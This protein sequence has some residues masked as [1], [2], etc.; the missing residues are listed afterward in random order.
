MPGAEDLNRDSRMEAALG[1]CCC[2][3]D[4]EGERDPALC[5]SVNRVFCTGH[6]QTGGHMGGRE[7][8][9]RLYTSN[10]TSSCDAKKKEKKEK[11]AECLQLQ[12]RPS[13]FSDGVIIIIQVII[14]LHCFTLSSPEALLSRPI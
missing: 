1:W 8:G 5:P 13:L 12:G 6:T 11:A 7:G 4:M 14:I 10:T 3:E 9:Q 2:L